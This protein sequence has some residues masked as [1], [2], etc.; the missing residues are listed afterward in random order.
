M[1]QL[2]QSSFNLSV[3]LIAGDLSRSAGSGL[4][5]SYSSG[6]LTS[7]LTARNSK[8]KVIAK[9]QSGS[10]QDGLKLQNTTM[11]LL[12]F[13]F[14]TNIN[15]SLGNSTFQKVNR[16]CHGLRNLNFKFERSMEVNFFCFYWL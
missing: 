10:C 14:L 16:V 13:I 8:A 7:L 3:C 5:T 1:Y 15:C 11:Q 4:V 2:I 12:S 6:R 9:Y